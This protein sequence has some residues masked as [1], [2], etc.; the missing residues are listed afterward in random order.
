MIWKNDVALLSDPYKQTKLFPKHEMFSL[1]SQINRCAISIPST[2][3][4][5]TAKS[6]N[7]HFKIFLENSL[8]SAYKW[9]TQLKVAKNEWY[10]TEEHYK[11]LTEKIQQLQRKIGAFIDRLS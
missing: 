6:S 4:E 5:E 3:S 1:I 10:L 2:I 11:Y 7:K 9:E 8:G